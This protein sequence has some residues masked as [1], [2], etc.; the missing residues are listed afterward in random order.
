[1]V[2]APIC[3]ACNM[4]VHLCLIC[5]SFEKHWFKTSHHSI[6]NSQI[7]HISWL[8]DHILIQNRHH[9]LKFSNYFVQSFVWDKKVFELRMLGNEMI[10]LLTV[11]ANYPMAI[12]DTHFFLKNLHFPHGC[13]RLLICWTLRHTLWLESLI[14][15]LICKKISIEP[16]YFYFLFT[17]RG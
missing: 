9:L 1:M 16:R 14:W 6:K 12:A 7:S 17:F 15:L 13:P 11:W 5:V 2:F 10:P 3:D 8:N 4:I